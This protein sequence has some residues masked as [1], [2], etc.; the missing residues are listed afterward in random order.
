[1]RLALLGLDDA[2]LQMGK[3]A[4]QT[5]RGSIVLACEVDR[6]RLAAAGFAATIDVEPW[7][8]LLVGAGDAAFPCD[9]VLVARDPEDDDRRLEQLRKLVQAGLPMLVAHP[10]H[11]SML[12]Y[13]EL[14]MIR[15]ET[16][17]VMAPLLPHRSH[18]LV[19]RIGELINAPGE[20]L[21]G[22]VDQI[23][24]ERAMSV[25]GLSAVTAQ[26]ARDVDLLRYLGGEVARLG[27]MGSPGAA[28]DGELLAYQNLAVQM[29]GANNRLLRWQ[30]VP[31]DEFGGGRLTISGSR[32]K[33]ILLMPEGE[34]PWR[35]ELRPI[36]GEPSTVDG[37]PW[38]ANAAAL[39]ELR[40]A[41][42]GQEL[43]SR[44]P[45]AAR[46]VELAETIE[47]SL[48]KGRTIEL[49]QEEFSDVSTFKGLMTSLGCGLLL[50]ALGLIVL[51]A[52]A[53][54]LLKRV[55]AVQ[56]A[57]IVAWLPVA[58]L[59]VF[60]LFLALQLLLKAAPQRNPTVQRTS[61]K[62]DEENQDDSTG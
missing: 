5:G 54:N 12:A 10:V 3:R 59:V 32:G 58:L 30:V 46:A 47:R 18:P 33:A 13:Y 53:A 52:L 23:A 1:M 50:A 60:V 51:G 22:A 21:I 28:A 57:K 41:V 49:H 2:T 38:D 25:R 17:C 4:Q 48:V 15:R 20:S 19:K 42:A 6:A 55:G 43:E 40:D 27:A 35:L 62:S 44:W 61:G 8:A 34:R 45:D 29:A 56:A 16:R 26:F 14:D 37:G 7:E 31:A 11:A 24:L 39:D 36:G 9:A